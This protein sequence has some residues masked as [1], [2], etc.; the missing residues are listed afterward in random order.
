LQRL[1][2]PERIVRRR[3]LG[4]SLLVLLALTIVVP[5]SAGPRS[6]T[7]TIT[8]NGSCSFTATYTWSGFAGS[9]LV[10]DVTLGYKEAGGL[11]VYFA[12][13]DFPDQVGSGGSISATFTLTGTPTLKAHQYFGRGNLFTA[14]KKNGPY[15][16]SSVRDSV[17]WSSNTAAQACGTVVT[18]S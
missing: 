1:S 15:T 2:R 11:L 17:V 10:A 12:S 6:A 14:A 3:L 5:A 4:S 16:L 8:D 13:A 9:G 18:V 7:T